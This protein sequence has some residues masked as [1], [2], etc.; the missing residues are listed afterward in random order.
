M[1]L[2]I[3]STYHCI[4]LISASQH[5]CCCYRRESQV[6][7]CLLNSLTRERWHGE[8]GGRG[9]T[10]RKGQ[11]KMGMTC[12]GLKIASIRVSGVWQRC[13][14]SL[15]FTTRRAFSTVRVKERQRIGAWEEDSKIIQGQELSLEQDWPS[16]GG[17]L[18]IWSLIDGKEKQFFVC[19]FFF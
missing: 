10:G 15:L 16:H 1:P 3:L 12:Q 11:I 14:S 9:E 8:Q 19:L 18:G 6:I 7:L 5:M 17:S 13:S 4:W 2:L